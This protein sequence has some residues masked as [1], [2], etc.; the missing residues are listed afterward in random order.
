MV[1][2]RPPEPKWLGARW[3]PPATVALCLVPLAVLI[4][5][6]LTGALFPNPIEA[7]V[8]GL[9]DWTL[10]LLLLTLAITPARRLTGWTRLVRLRRTIGLITFAYAVLHVLAYVGLDQ[11]FHL[12]TLWA[13][14]TKRAFIILGMV[15]FAIL[16]VLAATSPKAVVRR[17]GGRRWRRLHRLIYPAAILGVIH[18]AMMV[19]A[20]WGTAGEH[21]VILALLLVLRL[22]KP[23]L[24]G[25]FGGRG[26]AEG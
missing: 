4:G 16:A 21:A 17:L 26:G 18:H 24:A 3:V 5:Q 7:L 25:V 23:R 2:K 12:P 14:I 8:R 10:R 6:A 11:A 1:L 22:P 15:S 9:G 13:D 19:R 20:G